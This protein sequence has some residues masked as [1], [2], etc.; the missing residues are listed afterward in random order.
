MH[1]TTINIFTFTMLKTIVLKT[2]FLV[3]NKITNQSVHILDYYKNMQRMYF[4]NNMFIYLDLKQYIRFGVVEY[5]Y[6]NVHFK[7][8][9]TD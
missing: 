6:E 9:I 5:K 2:H 7:K 8:E 1:V 4:I 3:L